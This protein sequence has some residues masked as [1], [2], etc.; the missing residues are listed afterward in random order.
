MWPI[1]ICMSPD[2]VSICTLTV[3]SPKGTSVMT[4]FIFTACGIFAPP[5]SALASSPSLRTSAIHSSLKN[6]CLSATVSSVSSVPVGGTL[7][8]RYRRV[9]SGYAGRNARGTDRVSRAQPEVEAAGP[10]YRD[11]GVHQLRHVHPSLPR[12]VRRHLQSRHRRDH[13]PRAVLGMRQVCARVPGG[14]HL[15]GPGPG[16]H[17]R[18]L[19][20]R[21][22]LTGAAVCLNTPSFPAPSRSRRPAV[23]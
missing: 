11:G 10:A 15:R 17:P 2:V 20:D 16:A 21:A 7:A 13:R 9:P 4:W 3:P 22:P 5:P 18:R 23:P 1:S 14:L 6:G 8:A 12:S 19:V